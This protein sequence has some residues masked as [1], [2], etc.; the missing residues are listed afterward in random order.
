MNRK[1][2][3]KVVGTAIIPMLLTLLPPKTIQN[4]AIAVDLGIPPTN[5][6]HFV[7]P[8]DRARHSFLLPC[9]TTAI[10]LRSCS[11]TSCGG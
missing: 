8:T 3:I 7:T 5:I 11:K 1:R 4:S 2:G 6:S 10:S 9:L